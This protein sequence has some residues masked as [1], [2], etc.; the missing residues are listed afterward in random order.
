MVKKLLKNVDYLI[1]IIVVLIFV[2]GVIALKSASQGAGGDSVKYTKQIAWFIVGLI[3]SIG[4]IFFDYR[5][6]KKIS[7]PAYLIIL[8][9]LILVLRTKSINGAHSWFKLGFMSLQPS[10]FLKIV[11]IILI[12]T[13]IDYAENNKGINKIYNLFFCILIAAVPIFL[14][15]KQP[16]F[17]TALVCL[18]ILAMM[19]FSS[20]L[21]YKY[22]II[23]LALIII[24]APIIYNF[25]LPAHAKTR[26][27]VFLNPDLDPRGAGYNVI[28]SKL[29]VGSGMLF[30][31]GV[32]N[33]NQTQ[34][35]YLPMKT[36]DFIFSVIGEE[37]GF[38]FSALVVFLYAFLLIKII[39]LS[40]KVT[41]TFG[42][43]L[44]IGVF[45][46]IFAHV[47][48]N[49]GMCIGLFPITGIPLPFISYGG[50]SM[51]TNF[52]GIG[53]VLSVS[54]RRTKH[55]YMN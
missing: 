8:L 42:K 37:M 7:I 34:M 22:I 25:V 14:V 52:I 4:I 33:G 53:I 27:D 16:D 32:F 30:G 39:L 21:D 36:T 5:Y 47:I 31:M 17:G 2:I 40:R 10:E 26:I 13:F 3:G 1:L 43:L 50:S 51:L 38:V 24:S 54:A 55:S 49:I 18:T 28:Q 11:L 48:E 29:A 19:L 45:G 6:L 12:A 41:D 23:A 20:G 44:C 35:G 9:F 15:A 46:M